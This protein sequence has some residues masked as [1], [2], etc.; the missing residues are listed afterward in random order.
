MTT[1]NGHSVDTMRY[2]PEG[3]GIFHCHNPFG[4][5]MALGWTGPLTAMSTMY[6]S[7]G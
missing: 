1:N 3:R 5:T 6:I 7:L 4:C 2:K